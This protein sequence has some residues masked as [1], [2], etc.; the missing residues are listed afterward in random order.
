MIVDEEQRFGVKHKERLKQLKKAVDR[1][2]HERHAD[3]ANTTHVVVG[4]ARHVGDRDAA[5]GSA[6]DPDRGGA[7]SIRN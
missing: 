2:Q 1:D 7:I 5:Q 3:P 6:R 4:A